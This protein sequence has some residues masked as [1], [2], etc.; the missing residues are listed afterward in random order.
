M[1]NIIL[2]VL[3]VSSFAHVWFAVPNQ[4][5]NDDSF[6]CMACGCV[7]LTI[8]LVHCAHSHKITLFS[9]KS[10]SV[11]YGK[12]VLVKSMGINA[13]IDDGKPMPFV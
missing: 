3:N 7:A 5:F 12:F 11:R 1:V 4:C 8:Q 6:F 2:L 13:K 9:F 10:N